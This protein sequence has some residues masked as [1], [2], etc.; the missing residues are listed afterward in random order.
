[1]GAFK[2]LLPFGN[3]TI[4]EQ[5]LAPYLELD[6]AQTV[7]VLGHRAD[8]VRAQLAD[9]KLTFVENPDPDS[10][11][12]DSI[13]Y[14]VGALSNERAAILIT[15]ADLPGVS[16]EVIGKILEEYA[17][18]AELVVPTWKE[19]G[20]HPVLVGASLREELLAL[21]QEAGLRGLFARHQTLVRRL[22]VDSPFIARDLDKWDDYRALHREILGFEPDLPDPGVTRN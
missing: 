22:P 20:G 18:G 1:M 5:S 6:L 9:L 19:R 7:V 21:D 10:A 4:I 15:P 12:S 3:K 8:D 16:S 13:A 2:P 17:N 14:G 11:M